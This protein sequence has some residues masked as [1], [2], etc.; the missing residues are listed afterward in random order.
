MVIFGSYWC[1]YNTVVGNRRIDE[2]MFVAMSFMNKR[3]NVGPKTVPCGTP[4]VALDRLE[5]S[6]SMTTCC[7]RSFKKLLTQDKVLLRM[8]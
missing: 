3:N 1:I 6:P 4:E 7:N 5:D 8:P 2:E